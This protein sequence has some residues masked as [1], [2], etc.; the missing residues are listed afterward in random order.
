MKCV[1]LIGEVRHDCLAKWVKKND[2]K[3][4]FWCPTQKDGYMAA[5]SRRVGY[6]PFFLKQFVINSYVMLAFGFSSR[7]GV[8]KGETYPIILRFLILEKGTNLILV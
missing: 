6:F 7:L 5:K 4:L 8:K 2:A 1:A 3:I